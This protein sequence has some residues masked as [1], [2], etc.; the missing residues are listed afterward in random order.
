MACTNDQVIFTCGK[1]L[2]SWKKGAS[3]LSI[4]FSGYPNDRDL[5]VVAFDFLKEGVAE[6]W[7]LLTGFDSLEK[8]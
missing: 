5:C 4:T 8:K 2:K 3:P 6:P 1:L 7:G